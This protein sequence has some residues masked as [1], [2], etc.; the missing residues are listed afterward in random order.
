M[1]LPKFFAIVAY[2]V[3]GGIAKQGN[4]PWHFSED[5]KFFQTTTSSHTVIMGRVTYES[6]PST[7]R[8]LPN[9]TNIVVTSQPEITGAQTAPSL[10]KALQLAGKHADQGVYV[11]GGAKLFKEALDD[12]AYLCDGIYATELMENYDC[13][14]I[15]DLAFRDQ[16]DHDVLM[17][18]ENYTRRLYRFRSSVHP[19]EEYLNLIRKILREGDKRGDRTGVGTISLFGCR[20]EF[21]ISERLPVLTTKKVLWDKVIG[22]LLW[23]I[24][25]ST[26]VEDLHAMNIHFWDANCSREFLDRRGL[27]DYR[28]GD[29]GPVYGFQWRHWGAEYKGCDADYTGKGT[30]QLQ[31]VVN[32]LKQDPNSRRILLNAWN[33]GN[34]SEMCLPP[35]H[36]MAQFYVREGIYLDC[37]M[38][39]RSGDMFL[40]VPFNI[41]SYSVL[42]Y[43]LAHVANLKPG[44]FIHVLGDAHVYQNHVEAVEKQLN[45]TPRPFPTLQIKRNVSSIDEFSLDDFE[46]SNYNPAPFIRAPMAV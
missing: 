5:L 45:R 4:M 25:G 42:T 1:S 23:I 41:M 9:R 29:L 15:M 37:Q 38:Y 30:D 35:C 43:M 40:G 11:I 14:C 33:A 36:M 16:C 28:E 32:L 13:D 7:V 10:L 2:D 27:K 3:A 26:R 31:D 44:K 39:Q 20:M 19:E 34:L 8:P 21:D 22:E 12:F 24:S 6:L 17:S 46:L 18:N